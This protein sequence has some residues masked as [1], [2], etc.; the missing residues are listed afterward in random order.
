MYY[1]SQ[2]LVLVDMP[3][4]QVAMREYVLEAYTMAHPRVQ[5]DGLLSAGLGSPGC[6]GICGTP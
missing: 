6:E 3:M 2:L 5:D 4:P 1:N